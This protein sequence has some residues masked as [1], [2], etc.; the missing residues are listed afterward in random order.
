MKGWGLG[1]VWRN[2]AL[3]PDCERP[4]EMRWI[5]LKR[6]CS[7]RPLQLASQPSVNSRRD[8]S[9]LCS[10]GKPGS[11]FV[12]LH[13]N[14]TPLSPPP[15]PPSFHMIVAWLL[16]CNLKPQHNSCRGSSGT[17]QD[18]VGLGGGGIFPNGECKTLDSCCYA[19]C[20]FNLSSEQFTGE[21]CVSA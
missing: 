9:G 18:A 17:T 5:Q 10:W 6:T 1:F 7:C 15:T 4:A 3:N 14:A 2:L 20:S 13:L 19:L 8:T 12:A 16:H 21:T 11:L